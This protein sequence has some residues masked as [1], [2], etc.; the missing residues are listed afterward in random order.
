MAKATTQSP[1]FKARGINS[2]DRAAWIN[3]EGIIPNIGKE[4]QVASVKVN[5]AANATT[6]KLKIN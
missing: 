2:L 4:P 3:A 6:T 1:V 5:L